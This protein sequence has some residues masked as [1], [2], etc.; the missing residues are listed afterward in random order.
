MIHCPTV[1]PPT[2]GCWRVGR[3]Q[4][5]YYEWRHPEKVDLRKSRAGNRFDSYLGN[6]GVLYFASSPEVCFAETLARFRPKPSLATIAQRE[7]TPNGWMLPGSIPADWRQKR[8]LTRVQFV[9]P[10]PF[11]DIDSAE[12][13]AELQ[14]APDLADDWT[15]MKVDEI[16]LA[17]VVGTD[18]RVTRR[19]SQWAFEAVN[20]AGELRF[21]GI[22]YLSRLGADYECWAVFEQP[23]FAEVGRYPILLSE[24]AMQ[25]VADRFG[26]T[27]H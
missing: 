20:D 25:N 19:I 1:L 9:N 2:V 8:L 27:I 24:T 17:A 12:T 15:R 13:L 6:Y 11:L 16:D 23:E 14:A 26:L 4:E 7:W 10:L 18:R 3:V 22:R 5:P 21:G